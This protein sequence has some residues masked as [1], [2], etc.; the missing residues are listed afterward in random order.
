MS[1]N[2]PMETATSRWLASLLR[3]PETARIDW[4]DGRP[5]M[6]P[7]GAAFDAVRMPQE[8]VHAMA[9]SSVEDA[10]T[11]TLAEILDGPVIRDPHSWFYALVP[12]QTTETWLSPLATVLGRGAWLGV[13][14]VDR[15]APPGV[16]WAVPPV[17]VGSLCTPPVVA[18]LLR[19][20]ASRLEVPCR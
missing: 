6:L 4:Q 2:P 7:L 10:V 18:E 13:P 12:P 9:A 5:A 8:L 3:D 19:V 11:S 20:G 1:A 15:T 14:R 16:H 17:Q